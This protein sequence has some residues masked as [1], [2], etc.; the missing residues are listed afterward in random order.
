MALPNFIII[1]AGK[2]GTTALYH[3]L[4]QHPQVYLSPIKE[5][6]FFSL[7]GMTADFRGPGDEVS[8]REAVTTLAGYEALFAAVKPHHLAIGESSAKYL[9]DARAVLNIQRYVPRAKLIAILRNPADRA[10]S[11]YV[12]MLRAQRE[13]AASF[14]AALEDEERRI[15]AHWSQFW[16]YFRNGLYHD[17]LQ[18]YFAAFPREQI[19][20]VLH[21]DLAADALAVTRDLFAFLGVD[22][23]FA[24][25]TS[26]RPNVSGI[27]QGAAVRQLSKWR[28][29][30]R[31]YLWRLKPMIP[32]R[33][34][35]GLAN[36]ESRHVEI[37]KLD[38]ALRR[39]LLERYRSDIERTSALIGRDLSPWLA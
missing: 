11:N 36:F 21:D 33:L 26:Y 1:G 37:L 25:D 39:R 6:R 22:A 3:Y 17:S 5:P 14:E 9:H 27:P 31:P 19:R 30:L 12:H 7:E 32:Q 29:R 10:W 15:A 13:P 38:P 18:R 24:P 2:A 23:T 20:V 8:N 34:R 16:G 28:N 35:K 4:N